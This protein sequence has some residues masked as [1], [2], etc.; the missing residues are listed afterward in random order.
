[1][2]THSDT[3]IILQYRT[4]LLTVL[5]DQMSCH[6]Q[7]SKWWKT[8]RISH[9]MVPKYHE[10]GV[11]EQSNL[12]WLQDQRGQ[13]HKCLLAN[14]GGGGGGLTAIPALHV[15]SLRSLV[16]TS[17]WF[18]VTS[19]DLKLQKSALA[20]E[21]SF[22]IHYE[23]FLCVC[24]LCSMEVDNPLNYCTFRKAGTSPWPPVERALRW[25]E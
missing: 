25:L 15:T 8:P 9:V 6:S 19:D 5:S 1:M 7:S 11:G 14:R 3:L 13:W 12:C 18:H 2:A 16:L 21:A 24:L 23:S 10:A 4:C 22:T 20:P 17:R